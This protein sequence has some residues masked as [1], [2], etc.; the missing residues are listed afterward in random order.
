MCKS[1]YKNLLY[2]SNI[3]PVYTMTDIQSIY[4]RLFNSKN[5]N[6]G[7]FE[8]TYTNYNDMQNI[9]YYKT[10]TNKPPSLNIYALDMTA[11]DKKKKMRSFANYS[12]LMTIIAYVKRN[13]IKINDEN[14]SNLLNN[15]NLITTYYANNNPNYI[16]YLY[17]PNSNKNRFYRPK[18]VPPAPVGNAPVGNAP[19]GNAP[20]ASAPIASAPIASAPVAATTFVR[21]PNTF[22][23]LKSM[24]ADL[25]STTNDIIEYSMLNPEGFQN[26]EDN[27]IRLDTVMFRNTLLTILATSVV[28]YIF[29]EL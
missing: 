19:V 27:K 5:A 22:G 15:M 24:Y 12:D 20:V 25:D 9:I 11:T 8:K 17:N 23:K 6:N 10:P 29:I 1:E 13:R 26:P 28:Y 7:I 2:E 4:Y 18:P 16:P 21:N 3:Y 14:L